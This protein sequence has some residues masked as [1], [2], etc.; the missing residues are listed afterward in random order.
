MNVGYH[1]V[2]WIASTIFNKVHYFFLDN[3]Y[4]LVH[5]VH[6]EKFENTAKFIKKARKSMKLTQQQLADILGTKRYTIAK[7]ETAATEIPGS[8]ILTLQ[9]LLK[10]MK[11]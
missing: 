10:R 3:K 5:H 8:L 4:F 1:S 6:M 2:W 11:K 7:Y 9:K